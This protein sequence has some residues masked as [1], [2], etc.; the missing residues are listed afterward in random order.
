MLRKLTSALLLSGCLLAPGVAGAFRSKM[1]RNTAPFPVVIKGEQVPGLL[2]TSPL[3]LSAFTCHEGGVTPLVVQVDEVNP[4]GRVLPGSG[5]AAGTLAADSEPGKIDANDEIV[6]MLKDLGEPCPE[7]R[8]A[9]VQGRLVRVTA[10][11]PYLSDP[12]IIYLLAGDRA[13][14]PSREYVRYDPAGDLVGSSVISLGYLPGNASMLDRWISHEWKGREN[15]DL[16]DRQKARFRVKTLG[17]LL[18]INITEDDFDTTLEGVRAGPVRVVRE[19]NVKV[20][21]VPGLTIDSNLTYYHYER[22]W[23]GDVKFRMPK[24]AAAFTSSM[25]MIAV[26]DFAHNDGARV[27]T[28]KQPKGILVDGKMAA[29]EA[30]LG[31]GD[32][33]WYLSTGGFTLVGYMD[34]VGDEFPV[35]PRARFIDDVTRAMPPEEIRGAKAEAGYEFI[36]MEKLEART[37]HF[38]IVAALLPGFP[39]RGGSGFYSVQ[40]SPVTIEA[41]PVSPTH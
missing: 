9:K 8:L 35:T 30:S 5:L 17:S 10:R 36:G 32:E 31:L 39:E 26:L 14:R 40:R 22:L 27:S 21:P 33:P 29:E 18:T 38:I 16:L 15:V 11:A 23:L 3:G 37:Y 34:A 1:P 41:T 6:M 24:A 28:K 7:A 12:G 19:V 2:G 25:D 4:N 13:L 20:S